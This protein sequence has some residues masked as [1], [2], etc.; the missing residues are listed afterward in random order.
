MKPI[1][2]P[3]KADDKEA[4][5]NLQ[6]ALLFLLTKSVYKTYD[7]PNSPTEGELKE[8]KAKLLEE[9]QSGFYGDATKR[10]VFIFQIQQS[11]GDNFNGVVEEETAAK[12]NE[13]LKGLGA[14][15]ETVEL[16]A[17]SG[18]ITSVEGKPFEGL[19]VRAFDFD[20]S[21]PADQLG[22]PVTTYAN[23]NYSISFTE[24]DF[25]GSAAEKGPDVL[26]RVY[27]GDRLVGEST[28]RHN[29][30]KETSIDL[31]IRE[32]VL[33]WPDENVYLVSGKVFQNGKP[34]ANVKVAIYNVDM[35]EW[36][37]L[38]DTFTNRECNHQ[39]R[40]RQNFF[41]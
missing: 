38:A 39:S 32:E 17:V 21:T 27:P 20:P 7:A 35:R 10:L 30:K 23:A 37:H 3:V 12:L 25:K 6:A 24:K 31:Q 29:L 11:L 16:Y 40:N 26:I 18:R 36:Q 2:A 9:I 1:I 19:T 4:V 22:K 14:F 13:V 28:V 15:D 8:L 41:R 5:T 33:P 34:L